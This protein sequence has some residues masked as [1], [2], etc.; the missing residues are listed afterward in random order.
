MSCPFSLPR[1]VSSAAFVCWARFCRGCKLLEGGLSAMGCD[2]SAPLQHRRGHPATVC[3]LKGTAPT[4]CLPACSAATNVTRLSVTGR[5]CQFPA[6]YGGELVTDC[7][8]ISGTASCQV[9]GVLVVPNEHALR[10]VP[11]T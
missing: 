11:E 5:P 7:I 1:L 9:S 8:P 3:Q 10:I 2:V 6:L 4:R